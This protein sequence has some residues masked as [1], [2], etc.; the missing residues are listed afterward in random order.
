MEPVHRRIVENRWP[1]HFYSLD[2]FCYLKPNLNYIHINVHS[3]PV[4]PFQNVLDS[5]FPFIPPVNSYLCYPFFLPGSLGLEL[6]HRFPWLTAP[7]LLTPV[8]SCHVPWL[9][10]DSLL[11]VP[12]SWTQC[13]WELA[14]HNG[15][16]CRVTW[17]W[18]KIPTSQHHEWCDL[19]KVNTPHEDS[20]FWARKFHIH[21]WHTADLPILWLLL[22]FLLLLP[23]P[24]SDPSFFTTSSLCCQ[25]RRHLPDSQTKSKL[26]S[27][28]TPVP[29]DICY[30]IVANNNG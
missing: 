21:I 24:W 13:I 19:G 10:P 9:L 3:S 4:S 16:S 26:H 23:V 18:V 27:F 1:T 29:I 22:Q 8:M 28:F 12:S 20:V 30:V 5:G 15:E 17:T 7:P 14:W 11:R 2:H 25:S 6:P